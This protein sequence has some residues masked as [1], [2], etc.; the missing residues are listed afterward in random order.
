[1][2]YKMLGKTGFR[3]SKLGLGGANMG[4]AQRVTDREAET[5]VHA[6][7][8][9]GINFIDTAASYGESERRIGAALRGGRRDKV[10]LA[11]KV[12]KGAERESYSYDNTIRSVEESL[13]RLQTNC[14]DLIQLHSLERSGEETARNETIPAFL[15]L[16]EQG[17]VRAIG[18]S[19]RLASLM[20]P[21]VREGIVDAIQLFGTYTLIDHTANDTLFPYTRQNDIGVVMASPLWMGI[22]A[23]NPA[24]FLLNSK[25]MLAKSEER[26][27]QL[28]FLR[29]S[30]EPGSL[31]EPAMRF[32][33]SCPDAAVT[34]TGTTSAAE[35]EKNMS[36]CDQGL[37]P[38]DERR[39]LALFRGE[40]L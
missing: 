21:F 13:R 32:C 31:I 6:A 37:D 10:I 25:E 2:E 35:L 15:K 22:L 38:E 14:I 19:S 24:H 8:D 27:A 18:V 1:M 26:K 33:L 29:K 9:L 12:G 3:V 36:Y 5:V 28:A 16:K 23:D 34:L 30:A 20:E 4:D 40:P 39:V 11:S 7:I 17:K